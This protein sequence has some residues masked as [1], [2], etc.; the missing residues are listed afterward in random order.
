MLAS[1]GCLTAA[2]H[3]ADQH[4]HDPCCFEFSSELQPTHLFFYF[5]FYWPSFLLKTLE[6]FIEMR[7]ESSRE[8]KLQEVSFALAI[9]M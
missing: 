8:L 3:S 6:V 9:H 4:T 2:H 1:I 5:W 7:T